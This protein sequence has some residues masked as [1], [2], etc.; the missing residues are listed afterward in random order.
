MAVVAHFVHGR[1]RGHAARARTIAAELARRGHRVVLFAGEQALDLLRTGGP[2]E[3]VP[4]ESVMPGPSVVLRLPRRLR[5]DLGRLRALRPALVISDGDAPSV[6]AARRLEIPVLS[7]GHDQVFLRCRLPPG[8]PRLRVAHERLVAGLTSAGADRSVAVHF[9]PIDV[10]KAHARVVR[11]AR[12]DRPESLQGP[13]SD[14]G[15]IVA[16]L[17]DGAGVPILNAAAAAGRRVRLFASSGSL[18]AVAGL[19][20][21]GVELLPFDRDPFHQALRECSAVIATAGSNLLAESVLLNKPMLALH[22]PG[23]HEQR[24][25]ALLAEAA[26]VAMGAVIGGE[27]PGDRVADFLRQ[28]STGGFKRVDLEAELA[29]VSEVVAD[30]VA[31]LI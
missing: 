16:Y 18:A 29:P 22:R 24:I 13:Q 9:L 27:D 7:V 11:V 31:E 10:A 3:L 19:A 17:R 30:Q 2:F 12:P 25:N 5:G 26:G 20:A 8:L 28:V 4:V 14:D 23:D 1:G 6:R 15:S 21:A